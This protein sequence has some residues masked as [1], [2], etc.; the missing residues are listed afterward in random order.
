MNKN[1]PQSNT[2]EG[3]A[4]RRPGSAS[5]MWYVT[6]IALA[7]LLFL[8]FQNWVEARRFQKTLETRLSQI[9]NRLT[10]LSAK[11]NTAPA[12]AQQR[13]RGPD[14]NRVYAVKTEGRPSRGPK[15]APVTIAEF[16]DF[17]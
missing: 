4:I 11:V 17:Q 8:G 10:Q 2:R 15:D 13:P 12:R 6:L 3:P 1:I 5:M 16:S 9:D 14:P 7:V